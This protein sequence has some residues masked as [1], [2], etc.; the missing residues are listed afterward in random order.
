M[1]LLL[2][3]LLIL[4]LAGCGSAAPPTPLTASEALP[5]STP[6]APERTAPDESLLS[7]CPAEQATTLDA[8]REALAEGNQSYF[9]L[10]QVVGPP[11]AQMGS[12]LIILVYELEDGSEVF[13]AYG[14]LTNLVYARHQQED[15]TVEELVNSE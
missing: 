7:P 11:D 14:G 6:P 3:L 9:N 13:L 10:C 8:F 15:G 4:L 12:G 1:R 5:P 2:W